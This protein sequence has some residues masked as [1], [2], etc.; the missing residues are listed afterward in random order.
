MIAPLPED[1]PPMSR[2]TPRLLVAVFAVLLNET[3]V[4]V[5]LPSFIA[6][7]GVPVER[8]Q[9]LVSAY[10]L[11]LAGVLPSCGRLIL[12]L[13]PR[14]AFRGAIAVFLLGSALAAA[15]PVFELVVVARIVQAAGGALLLPLLTTTVLAEGGGSPGRALGRASLVVAIAPALGPAIAGLLVPLGW[16]ALFVPTAVVGLVLLLATRGDP[17]EPRDPVP[18]DLPS[19]V[20]AALAVGGGAAGIQLLLAPDAAA[21]SPV[22]VALV[23]VAL[24]AGAGFAVRQLRASPGTALLELR[25]LRRRRLALATLTIVVAIS[26]LFGVY[27]LLPLTAISSLGLTPLQAGLL[28]LPGGLLTGLAAPLVGRLADR[29]PAGALTVPGIAAMAG[30]ALA[31][32]TLPASGWPVLLGAHLVLSAGTALTMTPLY[33]SALRTVEPGDLPHASTL[34]SVAQ[35]GAAGVGTVA[36]VAVAAPASGIGYLVAA[37]LLAGGAVVQLVAARGGRE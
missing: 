17:R 33:T 31:F 27:T 5:A 32:S 19:A 16:R 36:L 12:R 23:G 26:G 25:V 22:G 24:A 10:L 15:A 2:L 20:L 37:A 28:M 13:G 4:G 8:A 18:L 7:F 1:R 6:E 34:L 30:A 29:I 14:R 3:T 35:Q 21:P 11:T 9:W